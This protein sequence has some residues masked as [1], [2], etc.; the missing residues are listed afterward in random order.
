[1]A[2]ILRLRQGIDIAAALWHKYSRLRQG[3]DTAAVLWHKYNEL[4]HGI[5]I[6]GCTVGCLPVIG[7]LCYYVVSLIEVL[8]ARKWLGQK[9]G[10]R[11]EISIYR[12]WKYGTSDDRWCAA[13]RFIA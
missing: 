13:Q 2:L 12:S 3:I 11:H 7:D 9:E 1:M 6:A 10:M 4:R 5:D 8:D